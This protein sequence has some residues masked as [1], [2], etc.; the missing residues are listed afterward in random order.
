MPNSD[1]CK[2]KIEHTICWHHTYGEHIPITCSKCNTIYSTKNID[3]IGARS[4]FLDKASG[5]KCS[6][7]SICDDHL[8]HICTN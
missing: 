3:Y 5:N 8:E 1:K 4:I 7:F 6:S 2:N